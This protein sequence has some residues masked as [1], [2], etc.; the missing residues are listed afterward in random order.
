MTSKKTTYISLI[1]GMLLGFY[2]VFGAQYLSTLVGNGYVEL[3]LNLTVVALL[4]VTGG[5][6]LRRDLAH[7]YPVAIFA[8]LYTAA[9]ASIL[10]PARYIHYMVYVVLVAAICVAMFGAANKFFGIKK[11]SNVQK[12]LVASGVFVVFFAACVAVGL[13]ISTTIILTLG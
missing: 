11:L 10:T 5:A 12:I 9:V 13:Y 1:Y 2:L 8:S 3:C 7:S 6:L 4:G